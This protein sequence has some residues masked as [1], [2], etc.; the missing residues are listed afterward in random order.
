[1]ELYISSFKSKQ[2]D[3]L[4]QWKLRYKV[5]NEDLNLSE[6]QYKMWTSVVKSALKAQNLKPQGHYLSA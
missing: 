6:I 5:G 3:A 4:R 1:M 2:G